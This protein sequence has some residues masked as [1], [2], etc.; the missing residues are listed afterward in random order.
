[1]INNFKVNTFIILKNVAWRTSTPYKEAEKVG[2]Y[3]RIKEAKK[4]L[5]I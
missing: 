2:P 1:M 5:S 4:N 3:D